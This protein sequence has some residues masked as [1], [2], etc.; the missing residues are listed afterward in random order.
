MYDTVNFWLNRGDIKGDISAIPQCLNNAIEGT[1]CDTGETWTTG[2]IGD[3]KVS[4]SM[5][6]VSIKGSLAK[7]LLP[8]N[9]Y[10]LTRHQVREAIE[11]LSDSLYLPVNCAKVT[12]IDISTNFIMSNE[13]TRYFDLLGLCTYYN[14]NQATDNTL[15]YH[16]KGKEHLR[17]MAFYD[18]AREVSDRYGS[19]P[20]VYKDTNLLRYEM[21]WNTRLPQQLNEPEIT[22]SLLYDPRFYHKLIK[23][24]ADNYFKIEKKK[25]LKTEAM[26]SIKTV[27][28]AAEYIYAI[29]LSKL[30]SDEVQN[31]L[32]TLKANGV[33]KDPKNYTRLKK[34]LSDIVSKTEISE[35]DE[36]AKELDNEIKQTLSYMR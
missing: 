2:K 13:A 3:L 34:K 24:W 29:A 1:N 10:T 36:L 33:F 32:R 31:V 5:A 17:T 19:I 20:D 28:D 23:S 4:V 26:N 18:K 35:A 30:P 6:G 14:R 7:F 27:T 16:N 8:D 11:K 25:Q 15:Y 21:R 12:R 22:G 9:T